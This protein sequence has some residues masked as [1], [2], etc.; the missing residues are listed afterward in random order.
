MNS[1][2]GIT[3][4]E[5]DGFHMMPSDDDKITF[6]FFKINEK[7]LQGETIGK[8]SVGDNYNVLLLKHDSEGVHIND[9]FEAIFSDPVVY[10]E[11]LVGMN[12]YGTFVKKTEES[13]KWFNDY[14][15]ET[16]EK[17]I[18]LNSKIKGDNNGTK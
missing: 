12:L 2:T 17:V 18:M 15:T 8:S 14:L 7:Y 6:S 13:Q 16:K 4:K 1:K 10:A 9:V 5:Y 3:T 11:R